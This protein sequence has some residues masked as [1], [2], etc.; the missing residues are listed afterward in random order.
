M[1]T[2]P[3]K[4]PTT[5]P[6]PA[7]ARGAS[8]K[9]PTRPQN[10]MRDLVEVLILVVVIF[11]GIKLSFESRPISGPSMEPG[12]HTEQY[13]LINKLDYIFG[14]P[15]RGDV[16]IFHYPKN[17]DEIF[18]KRII[19]L[20]G[21]TI[22]VTATTVTVNGVLL[23]EPYIASA[24]NC[25][26]HYPSPCQNETQKLGPDQ[27][28][29]MGDNRPVSDDSRVWGVLDRK[30]IIGKASFVWWPLS[31]FHGIDGHHAVFA[32]VPTPRGMTQTGDPLTFFFALPFG[33]AALR[34]RRFAANVR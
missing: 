12:L 21:D 28:W 25:S 31:A 16:I 24:D 8:A 7:A 23:N 11:L 32:K 1:Q 26:V 17:P 13:A 30:Y 4:K 5:K 18:I 14:S 22:V 27:F 2:A 20:P 6:I 19:G 3:T 34:A 9:A 29:A 10:P 33:A 15:Q